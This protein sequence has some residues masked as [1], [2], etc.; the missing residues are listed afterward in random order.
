MKSRLRQINLKRTAEL[1]V[2]PN[3][4]KE[5]NYNL[6][7][8]DYLSKELRTAGLS[9][10]KRDALVQVA[11]NKKYKDKYEDVIIDCMNGKMYLRGKDVNDK[12]WGRLRRF[13]NG[14]RTADAYH[15]TAQSATR[16]INRIKKLQEETKQQIFAGVKDEEII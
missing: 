1:T 2:Q 5:E 6:A 16:I 4:V 3:D 13:N 8:A 7:L 10:S 11:L 14:S 15:C 9:V 12:Y